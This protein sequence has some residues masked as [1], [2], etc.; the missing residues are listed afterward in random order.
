MFKIVGRI[1]RPNQVDSFTRQRSR[2]AYPR[3]HVEVK[4]DEQFPEEIR[5]EDE[6]GDMKIV[7][8]KYE[9]KPTLCTH[10]K[11]LGHEVRVCKKIEP[12]QSE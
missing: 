1:R 8:V 12:R 3:V 7:G 5:F 10:C 9:W 4:I 11:G 6:N 2:L